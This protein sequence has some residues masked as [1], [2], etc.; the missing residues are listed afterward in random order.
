MN[1]NRCRSAFGAAAV[2]ATLIATGAGVGPA[3]A[4]STGDQGHRTATSAAKD[5]DDDR[6]KGGKADKGGKGKSD[7][8][9]AKKLA[10]AVAVVEARFE[11]LLQKA[12]A[13]GADSFA[14]FSAN[15]EADRAFLAQ[16]AT[17]DD[18]RD[19][20][21]ENYEQVLAWARKVAEQVALVEAPDTAVTEAAAAALDALFAVTASS[22]KSDLRAAKQA[23]RVLKDLVEAQLEAGTTDPGTTDPGTTEPGATDPG[24]VG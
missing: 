14:R 20:R 23:V 8:N 6:S 12:E 1:R 17:A 9:D 16:L 15:I 13:L 7:K 21:V 19:L 22:D 18:V 4:A 3:L 24:T 5:K 11:R 2:I 10:K